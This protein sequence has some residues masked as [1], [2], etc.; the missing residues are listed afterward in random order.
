MSNY[1]DTRDLIKERNETK[2]TILDA[3]NDEFTTDYTDY[4]EIDFEL[5]DDNKEF[6]ELWKDELNSIREI[7][8]LEDNVDN[9]EFDFGT[10][11]ID[12]SDFEEYC[13]EELE[14]CGYMPKDFPTCI[15]IDWESTASNMQQD[16][17]EVEFRGT[18]YLYR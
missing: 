9:G 8:E 4:D 17:S 14:Q 18:T 6:Q 3:F 15:V 1:I 5:V 2:S 16:Y 13:E 12:E 7:D 11:L 10:T